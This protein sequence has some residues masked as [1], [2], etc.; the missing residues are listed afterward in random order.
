MAE[1]KDILSKFK[2]RVG[3]KAFQRFLSFKILFISLKL[4]KLKFP[5]RI[6]L[7]ESKKIKKQ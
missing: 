3:G 7:N 2:E 4:S 5:K 6:F 1:T